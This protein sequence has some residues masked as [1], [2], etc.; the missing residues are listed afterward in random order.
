M[1]RLRQE[2]QVGPVGIVHQQEHIMLPA[3]RCKGGNVRLISQIVRAGQVHRYGQLPICQLPLQVFRG[4]R[5]GQVCFLPLRVEPPHRHIQHR[6]SGKKGLVGV[7][8]SQNQ[9]AASPTSGILGGEKHHGPDAL[10]R[11]FRR[12]KGRAAKQSGGVFLASADDS[13]RFIQAVRS[14]NFR[15]IPRLHA[16]KGLTLVPRHMQTHPA[17]AGIALHEITDRRVHQ[18]RNARA[19][20]TAMAHSIRLRNR[21]QPYSYTPVTEPVAW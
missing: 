6:H 4:H 9:G 2:A 3:N 14:G 10:R 17:A 16:Q 11:P 8:G 7:P 13:L 15:D 19:T 12:I 1:G 21:V 20:A 18:S 5:T